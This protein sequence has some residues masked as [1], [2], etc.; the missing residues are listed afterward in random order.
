M[1]IKQ[2]PDEVWLPVMGYENDYLVSNYSRV[3]SIKFN[4]EVLLIPS[5]I[6]KK[7]RYKK[8]SLLLNG[9]RKY[10][11]IHRLSAINFVPNP[12]KL[13]EVNHKDKDRENNHT[14]NFEWAT[15]R[16]NNRHK[17]K[18]GAYTSSFMG[19]TYYP[20][21]KKWRSVIFH[22]KKQKTLGYY[23]TEEQAAEAY[24]KYCIDNGISLKYVA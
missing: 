13:P 14:S 2:L 16:E 18:N 9:K 17:H 3:L 5:V 20:R 8:I 4:K 24:Q 6:T 11:N 21:Y 7:K 12:L 19:V 23:L 22:N 10:F 1:Q 15:N